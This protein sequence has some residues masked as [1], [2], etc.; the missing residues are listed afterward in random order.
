MT[1]VHIELAVRRFRFFRKS[2]VRERELVHSSADGIETITARR[3]TMGKGQPGSALRQ[4]RAS[5]CGRNDGGAQRQRASRAVQGPS[6]RVGRSRHSGGNGLRR[7]GGSP[8][9]D[10]V[11]RV[12]SRAR[13]CPR[14]RRRVS[15]NV[16]HSRAP[17]SVGAGG[18]VARVLALRRRAPAWRFERGPR[19]SDEDA[20]SAGLR[21][22]PLTTQRV[23]WN[24]RKSDAVL[25]EELD[26]LPAKYRCAGRAVPPSGDDV[27]PR[28]PSAQ[29]AGGDG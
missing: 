23:R 5:A 15:G 8:R 2:Q 17:G 28:G 19:L 24:G 14:G 25:S 6:G 29:L 3:T 21:L 10:G 7:F 16:P 12:P 9:S 18:R 27:R 4:L 1:E 26:R 22:R 11:G 13:R 20:E